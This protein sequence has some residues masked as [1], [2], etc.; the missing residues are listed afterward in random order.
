MR[1]QLVLQFRG[2]SLADYD[3]MIALED[4]LIQEL[5]HSAKVDGHD[6]GSGE[7]NI[8]IF[9]SDPAATFWSVRQTLKLQGRLEAVTAAYRE[10]SSEQYTVLWPEGSTREFTVA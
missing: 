10:G 7:V 4:R 5:G 1:Y 8:F 3:Q 9:T 2:D 6:C